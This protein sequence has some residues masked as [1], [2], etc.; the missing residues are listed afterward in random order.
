[1]KTKIICLFVLLIVVLNVPVFADFSVQNTIKEESDPS[2]VYSSVDEENFVM[3][4]V[5]KNYISQNGL[6]SLRRCYFIT[7]YQFDTDGNVIDIGYKTQRGAE[8]GLSSELM[9]G[10][11]KR[12]TKWYFRTK[13]TLITNKDK[14]ELLCALNKDGRELNV[15]EGKWKIGTEDCQ[16]YKISGISLFE[17]EKYTSAGLLVNFRKESD[18]NYFT[19]AG[20]F[21]N[22][23]FTPFAFYFDESEDRLQF[24]GK[25]DE[26]REVTLCGI[27]LKVTATDHCT[28]IPKL[29]KEEYIAETLVISDKTVKKMYTSKIGKKVNDKDVILSTSITGRKLKK[30]K[31]ENLVFYIQEIKPQ[32]KK[33]NYFHVYANLGT[34]GP[35]GQADDM[36][37]TTTFEKCE[38]TRN[39]HSKDEKA[40]IK[41]IEI[42]GIQGIGKTIGAMSYN[43]EIPKKDDISIDMVHEGGPK[44]KTTM[45]K[46]TAELRA[47]HREAAEELAPEERFIVGITRGCI[48]PYQGIVKYTLDGVDFLFDYHEGIPSVFV[49]N[50][51]EETYT[52]KLG[53]DTYEIS[54]G[55]NL[56]LD[57]NITQ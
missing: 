5:N 48:I 21:S 14:T 31:R 3:L 32:G 18:N 26:A 57:K 39:L 2:F 1:M 46:V 24:I 6:T 23:E 9:V 44:G 41:L 25:S 13:I 27:T 12:I 7:D 28:L 4:P 42:M 38:A 52:M 17:E 34:N 29:S 51:S 49:Q 22:G 50:K 35:T 47:P 56:L 53:N 45:Q 30:G 55:S 16:G 19:M 40:E 11:F 15:N 36:T 37:L 54:S 43:V 8:L 33:A 20:E 10:G